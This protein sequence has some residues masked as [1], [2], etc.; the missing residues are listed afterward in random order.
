MRKSKAILINNRQKLSCTPNKELGE[1]MSAQKEYFLGQLPRNDDEWY[2]LM[3][4]Y[5]EWSDRD[6]AIN[7]EDFPISRGYTP[8]KFKKYGKYYEKFDEYHD[9]VC[10]KINARRWHLANSGKMDKDLYFKM[11]VYYNKSYAEEM[12]E[13]YKKIRPS[14]TQHINSG[15]SDVVFKVYDNKLI[16][17]DNVSQLDTQEMSSGAISRSQVD[18]ESEDRT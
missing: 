15:T 9:F 11:L 16:G 14:I 6:D 2:A 5:M 3:M 8:A 10:A 1:R 4:D 13:H 18:T 7:I 17:V 12:A